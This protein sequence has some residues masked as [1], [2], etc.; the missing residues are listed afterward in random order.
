MKFDV[1]SFSLKNQ[2]SLE[3]FD[4]NPLIAKRVQLAEDVRV[5]RTERRSEVVDEG[6][7]AG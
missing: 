3:K 1:P 4:E 6:E 7:H 2:A 5:G